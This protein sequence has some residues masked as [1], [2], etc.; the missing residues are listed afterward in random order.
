MA[1]GT[2]TYTH[3]AVDTPN[4]AAYLSDYGNPGIIYKVTGIAAPT[5]SLPLTSVPLGGGGTLPA[6]LLVVADAGLL[7]AFCNSNPAQLSSVNITNS[8]FAWNASLTFPAGSAY[9]QYDAMAHCD[10]YVYVFA[11]S[12]FRCSYRNNDF[13][14]AGQ[15]DIYTQ[16]AHAVAISPDASFLLLPTGNYDLLYVNL[17]TWALESSSRSGRDASIAGRPIVMSDNT[18]I[19]APSTFPAIFFFNRTTVRVDE[20]YPSLRPAFNATNLTTSAIKIATDTLGSW[21]CNVDS[22]ETYAFCGTLSNSPIRYDLH[23]FRVGVGNGPAVAPGST[24]QQYYCA[25]FENG[26]QKTSRGL[27]VA[28]D[29]TFYS[30]RVSDLSVV[31]NISLLGVGYWPAVVIDT[32]SA[33]AYVSTYTSTAPTYVHKI[34]DV[35]GASPIVVGN[36]TLNRTY[37]YEMILAGSYLY[38][39]LDG[40]P[41]AVFRV[42]QQNFSASNVTILDLPESWVTYDCFVRDASYLYTIAGGQ[43]VRIAYGDSDGSFYRVDSLQ[44]PSSWLTSIVL[45]GSDKRYLLC[46]SGG[47]DAIYVV[48][49][50]YFKVLPG[51]AFVPNALGAPISLKNSQTIYGLSYTTSDVY[52]FDFPLRTDTASMSISSNSTNTTSATESMS[53]TESS[54]ATSTKSRTV[55]PAPTR[56]KAKTRTRLD[57]ETRTNTKI[58]PPTTTTTT[59]TSSTTNP[60]TTTTTL[61]II[62]STSSTSSTST[63]TTA[64]LSTTTSTTAVAVIIPQQRQRT[65]T[66]VPLPPA[67]LAPAAAAASTSAG[68]TAAGAISGDLGAPMQTMVALSIAAVAGAC[69]GG[70]DYVAAPPPDEKLQWP[71]GSMVPE[72]QILLSSDATGDY[73]RRSYRGA[74]IA[75]FV[76]LPALVVGI[77]ALFTFL[78]RSTFLQQKL[79][80]SFVF[81]AKTS[82]QPEKLPEPDLIAD[83]RLFAATL[84]IFGL[85]LEGGACALAVLIA[86]PR[87]SPTSRGVDAFLVILSAMIILIT[88][89]ILAKIV[90]VSKEKFECVPSAI[91]LKKD[92]SA[93]S[94]AV[95]LLGRI[96]HGYSHW[97]LLDSVVDAT[98]TK[99]TFLRFRV[100][101]LKNL[102]PSQSNNNN[103]NSDTKINNKADSK[104]VTAPPPSKYKSI[105]QT[106]A[107]FTV[108]TSYACTFIQGITRG[109]VIAGYLNCN[110]AA[111]ILLIIQIFLLIWSVVIQSALAPITKI[112]NVATTS[113]LLY[114][115]ISMF[116]DASS[117]ASIAV[118]G[119]AVLSIAGTLIAVLKILMNFIFGWVIFPER[120]LQELLEK[121]ADS[122]EPNNSEMK[123]A[124]RSVLLEPLLLTSNMNQQTKNNDSDN[125]SLYHAEPPH[126]QQHQKDRDTRFDIILFDDDDDFIEL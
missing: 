60:S 26:T 71:Q 50:L 125:T 47:L 46:A 82:F 123:G 19:I 34:L 62:T 98:E 51:F 11:T 1:A 3:V 37:S 74:L 29:G 77:I 6:M 100:V 73:W 91:R 49:L 95:L 55:S 89:T 114:S 112:F 96:F 121:T 25:L 43:I 119:A 35:G 111:I 4:Q 45:L 40:D 12:L 9:G 75:N 79:A 81:S 14:I 124:S 67:V 68:A 86:A 107:M 23:P 70:V 87:A 22:Q 63:T 76:F 126:P 27:C 69:T 30:H 88:L 118:A 58:V 61:A 99:R 28:V 7:F 57:S 117:S 16:S 94:S 90:V 53:I 10:N 44:Q 104:N 20:E 48:D 56:T 15:L 21:S 64:S 2:S 93:P 24:R 38:G 31:F 115:T 13:A 101:F 106:I 80:A 52:V 85:G 103:N 41:I 108:L 122:Q 84:F 36:L 116:F 120:E 109:L 32:P 110:G 33:I 105:V 102:G 59:T 42:H 97:T 113:L 5:A 65:K 78:V 17:T 66:I 83:G 18:R 54:D 72:I 8:S 92:G 39:Q